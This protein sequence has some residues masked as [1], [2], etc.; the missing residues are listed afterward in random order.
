MSGPSQSQ[1]VSVCAIAR[2]G[3]Q[4]VGIL[5]TACFDDGHACKPGMCRPHAFTSQGSSN[6][7]DAQRNK[8]LYMLCHKALTH[9]P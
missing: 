9:E 2:T 8:K 4:M 6:V 5:C 1:S 7:C 3:M